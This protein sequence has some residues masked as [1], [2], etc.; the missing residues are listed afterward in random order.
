MTEK[1]ELYGPWFASIKGGSVC[2]KCHRPYIDEE[3]N[4]EHGT[5]LCYECFEDGVDEAEES[6]ATWYWMAP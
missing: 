6:P 5:G 2:K 1:L 4:D 3:D